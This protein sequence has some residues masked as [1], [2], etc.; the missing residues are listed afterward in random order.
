M[1]EAIITTAVAW[2][3]WS[4]CDQSRIKEGCSACGSRFPQHTYCKSVFITRYTDTVR[5]STIGKGLGKREVKHKNQR[6]WERMFRKVRG[7][8]LQTCQPHLLLAL[9]ADSLQST[10]YSSANSWTHTHIFSTFSIFFFR[11]E[12]NSYFTKSHSFCH[13]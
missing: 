13:L 10:H 11:T 4:W 2:S 12:R 5:C 9:M 6:D 7:V 1:K 8:Q 3:H